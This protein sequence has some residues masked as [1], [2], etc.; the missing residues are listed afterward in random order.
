MPMRSL[1]RWTVLAVVILSAGVAAQGQNL[2]G[3]WQGTLAAGPGLR[4][5]VVLTAN[6]AGGGYSAT[7]YSIDQTPVGLAATTTVQGGTV[8]INVAPAGVT[9]EGKLSPDGN[10]IVGN[11]VQGAGS[12][13][14]TLVRATKE[15]A[16]AIPT[17]PRAMAADAP[18]TF[19]VA[20]IKPSNPDFQG[21]L[22]TVKGREVLTLG[23][24]L[25]DLITFAYNVHTRQITGGQP[26][27]E[28]DKYDITG[29]PVAEGTPNDRQLREMIRTLLEERFK[30]TIHRDKRDMPAYAITVG[31]NPPKL[32]RNET[33]PNGLP[34]LL[35]KG[36]GVLPAINASMSDFARVL[37]GAVLD[38]PVIDRTGLQGR[39]DFTLNWTPDES[40]FRS[41]GV[42]VPPPPQD[43]SGPPGLFTA[44]QEQLGL[45]LESVTAPVEVIVIDRVERPTEN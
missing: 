42:R 40:Q 41:M 33:N 32:A 8:R 30:L 3:Q 7:F 36:L 6:A 26:W 29:R 45:R 35:F 24:T 20:T 28:S 37:Q 15:T 1:A 39:F 10:S 9:F 4:L 44:M 22:F 19:E 43:G 12:L 16:Y 31:A 2:A 5:V 34:A 14:M 27:M 23:T 13:P 17:P 18:T 11:F 38:R 25:T 21:K